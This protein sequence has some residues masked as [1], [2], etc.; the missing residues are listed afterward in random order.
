MATESNGDLDAAATAATRRVAGKLGLTAGSDLDVLR[1]AYLVA[2]EFQASMIVRIAD[3]MLADLHADVGTHGVDRVVA[4]G[5]DG[6]SLAIAM[7]Q[8]D[9]PFYRRHVSNLVLS[10]ALV[11][12]ALQD[13]EHHQGLSFPQVHGYRRVASRVDPADTVGAFR[14]L[15]DYLQAREVPV[16]RPGSRVTLFDTSFKGTVQELLAAVYPETAFRGRYAFFGESPH[17]PHPGS[18]TGYE[19][20]LTA[21]ESRQGRPFFVLPSDESLTFAHQLAINSVEEL[22]DGPMTT[23]VRIGP[24]GADQRGQ[25]NAPDLLVGLSRGRVSPRLRSLRVREGV[26]VVNLI[27]VADRARVSAALRDTGADYRASLE[28]GAARYRGE[29]RA[30]INGSEIDPR[31]AEFLDSFVH[32]ADKQQVELLD[33]ALSRAEV[34]DLEAAAIWAAYDRCADGDKQVFVQ[35]VLDSSQAGGGRRGQRARRRETDRGVARP[36][37]PEREL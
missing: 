7:H 3:D 28:D 20:H 2:H 1:D 22:M 5:R 29:V 17:D 35:N 33:R 31:L 32:R 34:P 16:G 12:N 30:W 27:A 9:R 10:R 24:F 19:V 15:S 36:G 11:E 14:V 26:K 21:A 4:L 25:H 13:L 37:R 8:L 23:P 6:H 18:K